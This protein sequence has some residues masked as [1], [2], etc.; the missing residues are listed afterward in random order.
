MVPVDEAQCLP[1]ILLS[2][3]R[4]AHAFGLNADRTRTDRLA[5]QLL[6]IVRILRF[7]RAWYILRNKTLSK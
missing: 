5:F 2:S 6:L 4:P 7:T 1:A 3:R